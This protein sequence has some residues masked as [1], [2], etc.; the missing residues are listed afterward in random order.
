MR[1]FI[2]AG[3]I[4][5][6]ILGVCTFA[7]VPAFATDSTSPRLLDE[8]LAGA[9]GGVEEIVFA[10]RQGGAGSHWYENFGYY[11]PQGLSRNGAIV[12]SRHQDRPRSHPARR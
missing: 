1:D 10:A 8:F 9:I 4:I 5:V 11:E 6:I 3:R 12:Q 7:A 2:P